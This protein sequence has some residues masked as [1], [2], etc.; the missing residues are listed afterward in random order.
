MKQIL[1]LVAFLLLGFQGVAQEKE[2]RN[3]EKFT[4]IQVSEAIELIITKGSK[5]EAVVEVD[6]IDLDDVVTEIRG[7]EL[8]IERRNDG[9][10]NNNNRGEVVVRLTYMELSELSVNSAASVFSKSLIKA[11]DFEIDISSAGSARLELDVTDLEVDISS[12]GTLEISG[13]CASMDLDASSAGRFDGYDLTCGNIKADVSSGGS[14]EVS[15]KDRLIV[16]AGS[17]GSLYY[18]GD[19]NKVIANSNLGGRVK[20][21]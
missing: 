5:N 3:L 1:T 16:D 17:G 13:T 21:R 11:D 18:K 20:R 15:V 7:S 2:T 9:R 6:D 19:P 4:A 10:N 14:G 8:K 12:A